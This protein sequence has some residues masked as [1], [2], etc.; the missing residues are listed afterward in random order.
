MK[1]LFKLIAFAALIGLSMSGCPDPEIKDMAAITINFGA[2]AN[3]R[4]ADYP[5]GEE[6]LSQLEFRVTMT[7]PT[8]T[9]DRT[10]SKGETK[11]VFLVVPGSWDIMLEAYLDDALYAT[12]SVEGFI[13]K[14]GNNTVT[15]TMSRYDVDIPAKTLVSISAVY[16]EENHPVYTTTPFDNLKNGLT[17]TAHY[18]GSFAAKELEDD[19]YTLTEIP[20]TEGQVTI[21]VSYTE[22]GVAKTTTFDVTVMP[23]PAH[24]ISLSAVAFDDADYGYAAI[25]AQ[26]V[27]V[28]NIGTQATG[29]LAIVIDPADGFDLS[30]ST[31]DGIAAGGTGSFTITPKIDLVVGTY[32]AIITVS[33]SDN[34]ISETLS[35]SF[36]VNKADPI[37]TWPTA[38]AITYGAALSASELIGGIGAGTFD[39][40]DDTIIPT[41]ANSGYQ[42]TF[43]PTDVDNYN[44]VAKTVDITVS[45]AT[46]IV[47]TWPTAAAI[48]YGAALS[49]STLSGGVVSVDGTFAWTNGAII[50]TVNNSGYEVTFTPTDAANYNTVANN[51]AAI[52]VNR[53]AG[54][55]VS[56]PAAAS[57][58]MNSITLNAATVSG[59]TGQPAEYAI[60]TAN[61]KTET[62]LSWQT[63]LTF[64][65]LSAGT[66]YAY[67]RSAQS[68]NYN[69]GEPMVSAAISTTL[70]DGIN[71]SV[72]QITD[73][74]TSIAEI[75]ISRTG[76][77]GKPVTCDVSVSNPAAYDAG[78]ISWAIAGVGVYTG[79]TITGTD[80]T[81]ETFKLDAE[82]VRYN[83]LGVHALTLTVA[84]DGAEYR[85]VIPFT[86]VE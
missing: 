42:V 56:E 85:R 32:S 53:A 20:L 68:D 47:T 24:G 57:V 73:A 23:P 48:T 76:S 39:W 10:F 33:N 14:A 72:E 49:T 71:L 41:V 51:T 65:G 15:I 66:Y 2:S 46:P 1:K 3:A 67:A 11:A 40:T 44:T 21:T 26:T 63:D 13:A 37:V 83:S 35:V 12:G 86:V 28:T 8:G 30:A 74:Q 78:S 4:A 64:S 79:T 7:G 61:D 19:E 52:T 50:P 22:G 70:I 58:T 29:D 38:A 77:S 80:E 5:P 55:A 16:D 54:A 60:S 25:S 75:T 69:A 62:E 17:V 31:I 81:F 18:S 36:T 43:T 59:N 6:I 27:T 82:D 84:R 45:K 34:G 9:Q